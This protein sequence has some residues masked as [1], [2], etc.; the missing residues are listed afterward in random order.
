MKYKLFLPLFLLIF[1]RTMSQSSRVYTKHLQATQKIQ[2]KTRVVTDITAN[3]ISGDSM[4]DA[5]LP[6]AKSVRD[7]VRSITLNGSTPSNSNSF[8]SSYTQYGYVF[9]STFQGSSLPAGVNDATPNATVVVN[10]RLELSGGN[11]NTQGITAN[12]GT[13]I[14]YSNRVEFDYYPFDKLLYY[15]QVVPQ[16][17]TSTS[18]GIAIGF[19]CNSLFFNNAARIRFDMSNTADSGRILFDYNFSSTPLTKSANLSYNTGDTLDI[20]VHRVL[21]D[22]KVVWLNRRTGKLVDISITGP[23]PLGTGGQ[24]YLGVL[25]GN[26]HITKLQVKTTNAT[27]NAYTFLGDSQTAGSGASGE[28]KTFVMQAFRG[29]KRKVNNLSNGSVTLSAMVTSHV[30]AAIK[31]NVPVVITAGYNDRRDLVT[32]TNEFRKRYDSIIQPI[33]RAGLP[34]IISTLVPANGASANFNTTIINLGNTYGLPVVRIDTVIKFRPNMIANDGIHIT[35]SANLLIAAE[36]NKVL[37]SALPSLFA[38]TTSPLTINVP[39]GRRNMNFLVVDNLGNTFQLPQETHDY[40]GNS[41]R[42]SGLSSGALKNSMVHVDL[43]VISDSSLEVRNKNGLLIGFNGGSTLDTNSVGSNIAITNVG[44]VGNGFPQRYGTFATNGQ[45]LLIQQISVRPNKGAFGPVTITGGKNFVHTYNSVNITGTG[46]LLLMNNSVLSPTTGNYGQY[47]GLGNHGVTTGSYN[48]MMSHVYD[49][50]AG[51][52]SGLPVSVAGLTGSIVMGTPYDYNGGTAP[53]NGEVLIAGYTR[54]DRLYTFGPRG[55]F[56]G[57]KV[58]WWPG[59][60]AGTNST[61]LP[62]EIGAMPGTGTGESGSI[63]FRF[64]TPGSSGTSLNPYST[65]TVQFERSV[66]NLYTL[67]DQSSSLRGIRPANWTTANRPASAGL[68]ETGFN[69]SESKLEYWNGSGWVQASSAPVTWSTAGRPSSPA[70]GERG[71][72]TNDSTYEYWNGEFWIKEKPYKVY[73]AILNQTGTSAPVAT[74]LENTLGTITFSRDSDGF[75]KINSSGLFTS[76]KTVVFFTGYN[77]LADFGLQGRVA[78]Y[79]TS[80]PERTNSLYLTADSDGTIKDFSIEI[81]VYR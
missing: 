10:N 12:T 41:F 50:N 2:L 79:P 76:N 30:P 66:T 48:I 13:D 36:I 75:Y 21:W 60:Q 65:T 46:N 70:L 47:F 28:D 33:R 72:N 24:M 67:L 81:R 3:M 57:T 8:G 43:P 52:G 69:T 71:F 9:N 14:G 32:D 39:V 56:S 15:I 25:G 44:V 31:L 16:D 64:A 59:H 78:I 73:T 34:V 77:V 58:T 23:S 40:I 1:T 68:G 37:S 6:T 19:K 26:Q 53:Q 45:N 20:F 7:F 4:S 62:L 54:G 61:G 38:D 74:V 29:D 22:L 18:A 35:D 42:N 17:K 5:K 63:K 55:A 51:G 80:F 49:Y 27:S 11:T